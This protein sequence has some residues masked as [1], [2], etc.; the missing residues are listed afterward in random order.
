MLLFA[1]PGITLEYFTQA[2]P[3]QAHSEV[4][5][6]AMQYSLASALNAIGIDSRTALAL[7]AV[8]YVAMSILGI[9]VARALVREKRDEALLI[10]VPP[11]FAV[12]GGTYMHVYQLVIAAPAIL[13]LLSTSFENKRFAVLLAFSFLGILTST[14]LETVYGGGLVRP[15]SPENA[16]SFAHSHGA[17]I[18]STI[19]E[20]WNLHRNPID[21]RQAVQIWL[22]KIPAAFG[23]LMFVASSLVESRAV[24]SRRMPAPIVGAEVHD[25]I[26]VRA[27]LNGLLHSRR[28]RQ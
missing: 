12:L 21:P 7:G 5:A 26:V 16:A 13:I 8:D 9:L 1:G 25:E 11:A 27:T 6:F 28:F 19:S 3:D 18:A 14:L 22:L 20:V 23:L 4:G 2:I 15:G 17:N 24:D 10:L